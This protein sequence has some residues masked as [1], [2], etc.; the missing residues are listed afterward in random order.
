[1]M[2]YNEFRELLQCLV[3]WYQTFCQYDVDRSGYIEAAELSRCIGEKFGEFNLIFECTC[4]S[5]R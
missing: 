3:F 1:M 5:T 2:Q 4:T